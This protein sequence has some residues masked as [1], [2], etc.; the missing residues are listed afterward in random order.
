MVLY[1]FPA[2][3][4]FG[5][6]KLTHIRRLFERGIVEV[7]GLVFEDFVEFAARNQELAG[8]LL[9]RIGRPQ[10]QLS[11]DRQTDNKVLREFMTWIVAKRKQ[12]PVTIVTLA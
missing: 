4:H 5:T 9:R 2:T 10:E 6:E 11:S 1:Q 7:L 12:A 3:V 8:E